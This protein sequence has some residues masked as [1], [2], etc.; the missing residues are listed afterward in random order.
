MDN[1]GRRPIL[2]LI[3]PAAGR[4]PGGVRA[5]EAHLP[6]QLFGVLAESGLQVELR[7]LVEDDDAGRLA[8][9]AAEEGRDVG[10]AGGDGTVGPAAAALLGTEATLGIVPL[11]TFNNIA[12]GVSIPTD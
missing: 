8:M 6:A 12:R 10:V 2:L 5:Q 7:E 11:G 3:N 1:D 4:K 9:A